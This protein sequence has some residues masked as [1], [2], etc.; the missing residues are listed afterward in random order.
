[1]SDAPRAASHHIPPPTFTR[2]KSRS[3]SSSRPFI[4]DGFQDAPPP[5]ANPI[6]VSYRRSDSPGVVSDDEFV[7]LPE[8]GYIH[9]VNGSPAHRTPKCYHTSPSPRTNHHREQTFDLNGEPFVFVDA[10]PSFEA[11]ARYE[12]S[13]KRSRARAGTTSTPKRPST[14]HQQPRPSSARKTPL[15]PAVATAADA[16]RHAIP[17]G[18][19]LRNWDPSESPIL[20]LGSVFDANSLGKWIYDW[21]V[22]RHGPATPISDVA[23]ELWLLLIKVGGKIRRGEDALSGTGPKIRRSEDRELVLGFVEAGEKLMQRL[24]KLL[25][26][27]EGPMLKA[28]RKK[29][30][31]A[32]LGKNAGVEF[33]ETLFGRERMLEGTERFMTSCRLWNMRWDANCEEILR[34]PTA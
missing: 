21:T 3:K 19:S 11:R 24:A 27:C 28:G 12:D 7:P 5:Y 23:G 16:A 6:H 9:I 29:G 34:S 33:V 8:G 13:P 18:Y 20:L 4:F 14:S 2:S 25:K 26:A 1:M 22:F 32:V 31:E 15:Q 17:S 10:Q 30:G